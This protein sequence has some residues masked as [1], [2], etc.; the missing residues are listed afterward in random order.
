MDYNEKFNDTFKEF[1]QDLIRV[2]PEDMDYRMYELAV[3]TTMTYYPTYVADTFHQKVTIP[4]GERIL[5]RDDTFFISHDFQEV[6]KTSQQ[7]VNANELITKLKECWVN[8]SDANKDII[9]KYFKV[10]ILITRKI[11]T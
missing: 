10:L 3:H 9:W 7:Q 5:Q 8:L 1:M 11:S 6:V 4:Y 2:F